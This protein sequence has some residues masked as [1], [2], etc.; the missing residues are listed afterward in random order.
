M[1]NATVRSLA[2]GA[3]LLLLVTRAAAQIDFPAMGNA[4][5][6]LNLGTVDVKRL[7]QKHGD[8]DFLANFL[9]QEVVDSK[10][11]PD[12]VI[13]AGPKVATEGSLPQD[14]FRQAGELKFP[15]FYMNYNLNP[16]ANPWRDAIGLAVKTLKGAEFTISR[17]RDLFFAWTDIIG[18]I[19]KSKLGRPGATVAPAAQ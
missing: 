12:A 17:P 2:N 11:Q 16:T 3:T 19:V 9:A 14:A 8:T 13:I 10:D 5:R 15:V 7:S 1:K 18:R 4:L 6:S